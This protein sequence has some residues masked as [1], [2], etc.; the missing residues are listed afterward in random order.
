M[1]QLFTNNASSTLNGA[2]TAAATSI[3]VNNGAA[4]SSPTGGDYELLTLFDGVDVDSST[5]VE[6]VKMTARSTNV[7]TVVRAQEGTTGFAFAD[8]DGVV[9]TLT[10][11]SADALKEGRA[12]LFKDVTEEV[13]TNT[14]T[15]FDPANGNVQVRTLAGNETPTFTNI[16]AGQSVL[17]KFVPGANT[18]TLSNIAKWTNGGTAPSTIAAEHWIVVSNI[19]GTIVGADVGGVS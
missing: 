18:L 14:G 3:T 11:G 6:I 2:I 15:D 13:Y 4:F 1:A 19:D 8:T 7:L 12:G 9:A 10:A 16:A 17:I 5:N